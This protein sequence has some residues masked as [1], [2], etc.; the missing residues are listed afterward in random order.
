MKIEMSYRRN[1]EVKQCNFSTPSRLNSQ[2]K[3]HLE[4][5]VVRMMISYIYDHEIERDEW[6]NAYIY[7][8]DVCL[9]EIDY[10]GNYI[11]KEG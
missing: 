5:F 11:I 10:V 9:G 4:R 3:Q 2:D 1:G 6:I 8:D 7:D